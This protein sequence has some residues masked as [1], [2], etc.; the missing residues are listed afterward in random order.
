MT[1]FAIIFAVCACWVLWE[2][3]TAP[4]D[5]DATPPNTVV[6]R[7]DGCGFHNHLI[8]KP[9]SWNCYHCDLHH[10]E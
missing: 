9:G 2:L 4:S 10:D 8:D 6:K 3:C 7:C 5:L 1:I